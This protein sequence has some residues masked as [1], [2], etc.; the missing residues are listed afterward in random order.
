MT[1]LP[2]GA[3]LA[4]GFRR[5]GVIGVGR[6]RFAAIAADPLQQRSHQ[7]QQDV[8]SRP[9][10]RGERRFPG[11]QRLHLAESRF[12]GKAESRV[13]RGILAFVV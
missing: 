13:N 3:A 5:L 11:E 1:V 7:R 6:R 12:D 10:G 4:F 8:Q 2:A 9:Q